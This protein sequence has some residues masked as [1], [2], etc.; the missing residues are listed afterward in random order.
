MRYDVVDI[1]VLVVAE[2]D[3]TH[4]GDRCQETAS[5]KLLHVR[6]QHSLVLDTSREILG[7]YAKGLGSGGASG[8]GEL[9]FI[10]AVSSGGHRYVEL[11]THVDRGFEA[12]P[13]DPRLDRFDWDDR[14]FVAAAVVSG[15]TET[16]IVNAVDSDYLL[17]KEALDEVGVVIQELC[18]EQLPQV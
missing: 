12:F 4:A 15:T 16:R 17:H 3:Q 11:E 9:F 13:D 6:D 1:N 8:P 5:L 2:G 7:E 18:P 10:W 14:K